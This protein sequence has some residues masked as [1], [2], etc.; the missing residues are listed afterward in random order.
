MCRKQVTG[1]HAGH[2]STSAPLREL[3]AV[4]DVMSGLEVVVGEANSVPPDGAHI[5][6]AWDFEV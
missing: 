5:T 1:P 2:R 4:Q 6:I 3:G